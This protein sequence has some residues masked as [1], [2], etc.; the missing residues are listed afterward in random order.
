[1]ASKGGDEMTM[2]RSSL[3][4]RF[5]QSMVAWALLA[6]STVKVWLYLFLK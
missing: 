2:S 1:M 3:R 4:I 6:G 5:T